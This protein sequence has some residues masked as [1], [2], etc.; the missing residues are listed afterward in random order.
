MAFSTT[1]NI[2]L[3][4]AVINGF[5]EI[6]DGQRTLRTKLTPADVLDLIPGSSTTRLWDGNSRI[7]HQEWI[8]LPQYDRSSTTRPPEDWYQILRDAAES[9]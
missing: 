4:L 5:V 2:E 7:V 1:I 3:K 9:A 8:V 6:P